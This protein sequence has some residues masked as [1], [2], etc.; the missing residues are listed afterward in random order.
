MNE[1][2][3]DDLALALGREPLA[4]GQ[5]TVDGVVVRGGASIDTRQLKSGQLFVCLRGEKS[6]GHLYLADAI[7]AGAGAILVEERALLG[8]MLELPDRDHGPCIFCVDSGEEALLDLARYHRRR[9]HALCFGVTGSN[10]KTSAKEM[11]QALLQQGPRAPVYATRGNL[12][13]HL[14]LP[15]SILEIDS[16]IASVVLEMGMN[17]AGEIALLSDV[18][19]PQHSIITSIGPAHIENF[20]AIEGIVQAKLEI[21]EAM[22]AGG[23]LAYHASSPGVE[24]AQQCAARRGLQLLLFDLDRKPTQRCA[25]TA[26][27]LELRLSAAGLS[28]L[29]EETGLRVLAPAYAH[30]AMAQNLIGALG[31]LAASGLPAQKLAEAAIGTRS[32]SPRRFEL[33]RLPRP[34]RPEQLLIDDSYNANPAS[35]ESAIRALRR[36][37]PEGRLALFAGEMGEQGDFGPAGHQAVGAAAAAAGYAFCAVAGSKLASA[38][39]QGYAS[40]GESLQ[41]GDSQELAAVLDSTLLSGFDGILVKGS[42]S[43][44]MEAVSDRLR[45]MEYV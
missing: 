35:F 15:L 44:R 16:E 34:G 20:G 8:G 11:L 29:W 17:H 41:A 10:G 23:W 27:A 3:I 38:I 31:L 43:A 28:F 13:N 12:N 32:L 45:T 14:G 42:R 26:T 19:G 33:H 18:A 22:P 21:A 25:A 2:R 36:L 6:D 9:L 4:V 40:A 39:L 30:A 5:A 24:A 1:W 7:A 37:L